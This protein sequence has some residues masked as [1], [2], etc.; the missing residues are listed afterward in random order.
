MARINVVK[1][2]GNILDD[3]EQLNEFLKL[4]AQLQEPS[5]LVHGGGKMTTEMCSRLGIETKMVDGRRITD[6]ASLEVAVMVFAG[7]LNK[8]MVAKL[9]ALDCNAIGLSGPDG[10]VIDARKRPITNNIDYGEVG[11]IISVSGHLIK[12]FLQLGFTP[13]VS[14]ITANL[15]TGA[16]L[17]TNADTVALEVASALTTHFETHLIFCFEKDGVIIN[18]SGEVA[19]TLNIDQAKQYQKEGIIN[20]GMLPKLTASFKALDRGV[21]TVR[22]GHYRQLRQIEA[23]KTGTLLESGDS[24]WA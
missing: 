17:N 13:V 23:G 18:Q 1:I 2:G 6:P 10:G 11:D 12:Q 14:P 7:Y 24:E 22:I 19:Q 21:K 16:L 9:Q 5:V 8:T 15:S 3:Q 4:F 20:T